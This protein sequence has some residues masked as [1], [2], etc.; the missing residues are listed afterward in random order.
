MTAA[1]R[2]AGAMDEITAWHLDRRG[3][4]VSTDMLGDDRPEERDAYSAR[5]LEWLDEGSTR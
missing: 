5:T 3:Y 2:Q 4:P 1:V